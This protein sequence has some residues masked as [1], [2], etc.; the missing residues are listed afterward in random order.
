MK[1]FLII[2]GLIL[3]SLIITFV[4]FQNLS[5]YNFG[6]IPTKVVKLRLVIFFIFVLFILTSLYFIIK[7]IILKK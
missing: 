7:K 1:K 6:D 4:V 3:I 5:W 2:S